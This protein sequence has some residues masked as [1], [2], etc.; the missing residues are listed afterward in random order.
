M[1]TFAPSIER[2]TATRPYRDGQH[3]V[4]YMRRLNATQ[5]LPQPYRVLVSYGECPT[6]RH[7]EPVKEPRA[8]RKPKPDTK[9]EQANYRRLRNIGGVD[10]LVCHRCKHPKTL[11][12]FY[13]NARCRFKR[14]VYCKTC[15]G[16]MNR[17]C[18]AKRER[19]MAGV[20][21]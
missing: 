11:D 10:Y 1:N 18:K 6:V 8:R 12:D 3:A 13:P 19:A 21:A 15:K 14:D 7:P 20:A 16:E 17:E 2:Y 5:W 4:R 9:R